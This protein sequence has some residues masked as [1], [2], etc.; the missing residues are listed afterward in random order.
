MNGFSLDR[1]RGWALGAVGLLL[2][3]PLACAKPQTAA[4][5]PEAPPAVVSTAPVS[6]STLAESLTYAGNIQSESTVNV[7]PRATGR[8][9]S[10]TWTSAASSRP[11]TASPS[12]TRRSSTRASSRPMARCRWP[13]P[14][15]TWCPPARPE[16][17]DAARAQV[18]A[19][20]AKL[21]QLM[22]GGRAQDVASAESE[23]VA[24]QAKLRQV[25]DGGNDA[26]VA[27]ERRRGS[28]ARH[29]V[30]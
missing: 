4:E 15:S 21:D 6:Q 16:D 3:A 26:Q 10:S 24:A 1:P 25:V 22:A 18:G 27:D 9:T 20:E 28:G 29:T 12:W 8:W 5:K 23:V 19:A 2:L 14:S 17:I 30:Q 11:A 7:R 13:R